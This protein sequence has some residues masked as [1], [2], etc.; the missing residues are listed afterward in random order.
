ML[1]FIKKPL[2]AAFLFVLS[3]SLVSRR[4]RAIGRKLNLGHRYGRGSN[5]R[6]SHQCSRGNS[7]SG[8]RLQPDCTDGQCRK[9][10]HPQHSVQSLSPRDQRAG[11]APYAQDVDVRSVVPVNLNIT[12]QVKGS[13]GN[14][15]R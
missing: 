13:I 15:D 14:R 2:F 9:I 10:Q 11:F 8:Q 12:L 1:A 3:L 5:R 6:G 4:E 7:Q